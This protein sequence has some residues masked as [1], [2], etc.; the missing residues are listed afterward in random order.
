MATTTRKRPPDLPARTRYEDDLYAWVQ[1]QVALLQAGRVDEIDAANIA[2]ELG[3]VGK[4]EFR[5]LTSAVEVLAM[6]LLKWDY[7]P[8][9]RSR[10][11]VLTISTQRARIDMVL[12]DSPGLKSR[13]AT[14]ID[15]G[16]RIGRKRAL[17]ETGLHGKTLPEI[18]P[19]TWDDI[20]SRPI[21]LDPDDE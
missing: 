21:A 9:K 11:W 7:Q 14:A 16:Y 5:S 4:S 19:Y 10:S 18:C 6:H 2:E 13:V 20:V 8:E 3:D 15:D 17:D 1:E 12:R